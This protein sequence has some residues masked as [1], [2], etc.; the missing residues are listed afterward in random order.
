MVTISCHLGKVIRSRH[1]FGELTPMGRIICING[2]FCHLDR[3]FANL[4]FAKCYID[5][6]IVFSLT[7]RNHMHHCGKCLKD[8]KNTT[9]SFIQVSVD[10]F[11]LSW[12][13]WV[14]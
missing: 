9:L 4:S 14:T 8:L 5:G 3:V 11:I 13:T 10:S 7:P 1:H 12:S 2:N 6:I